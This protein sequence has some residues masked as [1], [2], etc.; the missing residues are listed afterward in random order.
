[1]YLFLSS[2]YTFRASQRSLSGDRT[3]LIHHLVWLF[4]VK[5]QHGM[6]VRFLLTS[7]QSSHLHRLIIPDDVLIQFDLLMMSA[8]MLETCR[9]KKE[10]NTW[11]SAS[12]WLLAR[13][14][15][16]KTIRTPCSRPSWMQ[17][18]AWTE[19]LQLYYVYKNRIM[20][21]VNDPQKRVTNMVDLGQSCLLNALWTLPPKQHGKTL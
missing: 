13:I 18:A 14:C 16:N 19:N 1:M 12:S 4:C 15:N 10:I 6:L 21:P 9:E 17:I 20:K 3:V 11:K 2:L 7:I 5:W 8:V